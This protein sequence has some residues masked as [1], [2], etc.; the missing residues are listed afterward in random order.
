MT[1]ITQLKKQKKNLE[2]G[3]KLFDKIETT[4][5]KALDKLKKKYSLS[6]YNYGEDIRYELEENIEEIESE[7]ENPPSNHQDKLV[8]KGF[9]KEVYKK[10][11]LRRDRKGPVIVV[12][13]IPAKAKRSQDVDDGFKCRASEAKVLHIESL[14]GKKLTAKT[15]RSGYDD[16][17]LYTVDQTVKPKYAFDTTGYAC[18]SGIHFFM[19]REQA[20]QY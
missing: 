1:T 6:S 17:F 16:T 2:N 14:N 19:T 8:K 12:L 3:I 13:Q 10:A 9:L 15:A 7:I 4:Y 5:E 11:Y 20:V 18:A